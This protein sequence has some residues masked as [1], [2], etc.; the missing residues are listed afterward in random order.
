MSNDSN[1]KPVEKQTRF[2]EMLDWYDENHNGDWFE[3]AK[4]V[5]FEPTRK[6]LFYKERGK[7]V[8]DPITSPWV[9]DVHAS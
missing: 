7:S 6:P 4:F 3:T 2:E 8:P 1:K 5:V 9:C